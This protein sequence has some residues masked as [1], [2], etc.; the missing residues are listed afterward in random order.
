MTRARL[1]SAR[2]SIAKIAVAGVLVGL[3]LG[4]VSIPA[5]AAP[6]GTPSVLPAPLPADPPSTAPEPPAPPTHT[7]YTETEDWWGYGMDSGGGG[8][9]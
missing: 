6:A 1:S 3:P 7:Y 9:G 4:A 5:N 8:G 2:G